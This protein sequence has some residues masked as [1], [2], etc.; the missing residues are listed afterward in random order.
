VSPYADANAVKYVKTTDEGEE[1]FYD[2]ALAFQVLFGYLRKKRLSVALNVALAHE[3]H[4]PY[5]DAMSIKKEDLKY[6]E[7]TEA[8]T[9]TIWTKKHDVPLTLY[10]DDK[11]TTLVK[12]YIRRKK[13]PDFW[14]TMRLIN[15]TIKYLGLHWD[16]ESRLV[17]GF[18]LRPRKRNQ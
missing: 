13:L 11:Q 2:P 8:H 7:L 4:L 12:A 14:V 16:T 18:K 17:T 1:Y 5:W 10:L 3:L 9:I 6:S 15:A